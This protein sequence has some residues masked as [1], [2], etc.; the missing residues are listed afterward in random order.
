[1]NLF[2]SSLS[3]PG[4]LFNRSVSSRFRSSD[5]SFSNPMLHL[6]KLSAVTLVPSRFFANAYTLTPLLVSKRFKRRGRKRGDWQ[7]LLLHNVID[8]LELFALSS[9]QTFLQSILV[10]SNSTYTPLPIRVTRSLLAGVCWE[11][12]RMRTILPFLRILRRILVEQKGGMILLRQRALLRLL[13][14]TFRVTRLGRLEC[15]WW[16]DWGYL[17]GFRRW[18]VSESSLRRR[19]SLI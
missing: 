7:L 8:L 18:G 10:I 2:A 15:R 13:L 12:G 9:K 6:A 11:E 5:I 19:S 1:M 14:L 16:G 3:F 17:R 4:K